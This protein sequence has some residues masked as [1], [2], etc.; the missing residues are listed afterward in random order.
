[1]SAGLSPKS[2]NS[3]PDFSGTGA[4]EPSR[5][6]AGV[7]GS[8]TGTAASGHEMKV[9]ISGSV[10]YEPLSLL[11]DLAGAGAPARLA[12]SVESFSAAKAYGQS[13]PRPLQPDDESALGPV[14]CTFEIL[15]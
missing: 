3:V 6:G 5:P 11:A 14:T 4:E 8:L 1:M 15:V 12:D 2:A 7:H 9:T 13:S 10:V